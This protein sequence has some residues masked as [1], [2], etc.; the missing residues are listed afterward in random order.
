MAG[1]VKFRFSLS[2][3]DTR[4]CYR[5]LSHSPAIP[6]LPIRAGEVSSSRATSLA[7]WR[8]FMCG[9]KLERE[10]TRLEVEEHGCH[11]S[12]PAAAEE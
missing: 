10:S 9:G 1:F 3:F 5:H 6:P 2:R 4:A 7:P 12:T 8:V 11:N